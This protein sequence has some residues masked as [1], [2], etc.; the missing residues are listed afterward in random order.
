[1]KRFS[2]LFIL[3]IFHLFT[4]SLF[5]QSD[6][7]L[8]L[9]SGPGRG[10]EGAA[11]ICDGN[12]ATKWCIDAPRQMPYTIVLD[13]GQTTTIAEYGLVTGDDTGSYPERNPA[14]WR[15][16]GS[17]D[18]QTWVTIDDQKNNRSMPDEDLQEYRFK[19]TNKGSYRYYRFEF[20]R[21]KDGTRIQLSEINFYTTVQTPV[22]TTFVSGSGTGKEGA[23]MAVDSHLYTKWCIDAPRQMPYNIVL[24]TDQPT[25]ISEYRLV[26]G[27]DT[28][29]YPD[30]NPVTWRMS[31][32]ND[33]Q[34]W[35]TLDEQKNN[36]RLRDENEQEYRFKPE[37]KGSFRYYRFEF[38]RM[39]AGT[40]L[41]LSEIKL[42]K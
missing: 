33:K 14:T 9:V 10:Q 19:P 6:I 35:T 13:A 1:M 18:N 27:D 17:N 16:S 4:S 32:S 38:I 8:T 42:Y 31:G 34:K 22:K 39:T 24:D 11:M 28:H 25:V 5:A 40:R 23:E 41:Q 21:M 29:T 15:L 2:H 12:I 30:R 36:R 20:F 37:G 3:S 7:K 26:T